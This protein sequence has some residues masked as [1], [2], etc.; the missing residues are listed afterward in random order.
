M[1]QHDEYG[2]LLMKKAAGSAYKCEGD[3]VKVDYNAGRPARIDGTVGENIAVEIESRVSK[4]IRGAVL[5][6]IFHSYP[7]KLLLILPV[8]ANN[9][10]DVKK[11]CEYILSRYV[12]PEKFR[13]VLTKGTGNDH[14]FKIDVQLVKKALKEL[15]FSANS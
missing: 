11:Q 12:P 5:D 4:Q 14:R 13:V 9:P 7:K 1:N 3:S 10:S 15:G 6:L 8:H 2:K